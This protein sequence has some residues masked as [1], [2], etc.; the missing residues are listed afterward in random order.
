MLTQGKHEELVEQRG[1]YF[2]FL[3]LCNAISDKPAQRARTTRM[4]NARSRA[5]PTG[6]DTND[7]VAA[8]GDALR[9]INASS[10]ITSL[11]QTDKPAPPERTSLVAPP[12]FKKIKAAFKMGNAPPAAAK[13][14]A[15]ATTTTAAA[16]AEASAQPVIEPIKKAIS[17]GR[18][19]DAS[20]TATVQWNAGPGGASN[21]TAGGGGARGSSAMSSSR[22]VVDLTC[23]APTP[24]P[25]AGGADTGDSDEE[26][27]K[28]LRDPDEVFEEF[29]LEYMNY[30]HSSVRSDDGDDDGQTLPTV[31]YG[32]SKTARRKP[33]MEVR[34]QYRTHTHMSVHEHAHPPRAHM[35]KA[36]EHTPMYACTCTYIVLICILACMLLTYVPAAG[37][38]KSAI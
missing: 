17:I 9:P 38:F 27:D 31:F 36:N 35:H 26:D 24:A 30:A 32:N 21:R 8:N 2:R 37:P 14:A 25:H 4:M 34:P 10:S 15:A 7:D 33:P 18:G 23:N 28:Q 22:R 12:G 29:G 1:A 19:S 16:S 11:P 3:K 13:P 6:K 5:P 20:G